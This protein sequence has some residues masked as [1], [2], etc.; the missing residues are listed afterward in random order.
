MCV[1]CGCS[2]HNETTITNPQTGVKMTLDKHH[3]HTHTLPDGTV[4]NHTHF[5]DYTPENHDH[6]TTEFHAKT[7]RTTISLEQAILQ[8][9]DMIAAQNRGWFKG[10]NIFAINLVSSPGSG[11]TTLLT[12]TINDLKSDLTFNVIE[13]DQETV[14]DAE[15]IRQTGCKVVQINTGK[16]CH[17]EAAMV[18]KGYTELN[19]PLNSVL[20]IENVGNLVCPALFDLGENCKVAI[21]SVTEGEDKP[22]KYPYMFRESQV[23]ILTKIDLLPYVQFDVNSCIE[24][25]KQVNP[26]IRIFQVSAVTGKGLNEWYDWLKS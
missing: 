25:A 22:I 23:M 17:L 19:P 5:H 13:G 4:I 15:K 6:E 11:K 9:N 18:E 20:M 12:R 26:Q 24:Y 10:R 16:G 7:N 3:S 1:T 8:K 14:N 21:L 2:G